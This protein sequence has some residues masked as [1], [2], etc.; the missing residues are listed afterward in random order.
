MIAYGLVERDAKLTNFGK[1][2]FD[3]ADDKTLYE[4]FARHILLNL[5]GMNFVQC[6]L[7]MSAAGETIDL[8]KLR[9][10]LE[11]RGIH[12]PRGGKHPS[13]MRLWLEKGGV[14]DSGYRVNEANL[15]RILGTSTDEFSALAM[16]TKEQQTFLKT[17][18]A[19]PW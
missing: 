14:F 5:H 13:M 15:H 8:I 1:M 12:Y 11:E 9:E 2:L 17:F 6:I 16:Q 4:T 3:C 19:I 10:R 18:T 7:D